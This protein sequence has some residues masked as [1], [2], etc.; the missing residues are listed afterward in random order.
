MC[1]TNKPNRETD[2]SS[3]DKVIG[4]LLQVLLLCSKFVPVYVS[5]DVGFLY[6]NLTDNHSLSL[7]NDDEAED[8]Q[9]DRLGQAARQTDM[10]K[11]KQQQKY[12]KPTQN[13]ASIHVWLPTAGLIQYNETFV[14]DTSII[15]VLYFL[16]R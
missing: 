5:C 2:I 7:T 6:R 8:N 12:S 14:R 15:F 10:W 13:N 9:R 1:Y 3:T 16:S 11:H 4:N